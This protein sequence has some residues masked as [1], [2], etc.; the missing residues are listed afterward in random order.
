M[1]TENVA[2]KLA[3][4]RRQSLMV[5]EFFYF[6]LRLRKNEVRRVAQLVAA[7]YPEDEPARN[8]RRLI[9]SK[10]SLS[11]LGGALLN[12]PW[13]LP[14]FGQALKLSGVVG[15]GSLLTR[16]HLYLILEIAHL[17]GEDIDDSARVPEMIAVVAATGLGAA[18]PSLL[19][20]YGMKPALMLPA[21][22]LSMATVTRLVGSSANRFYAARAA[23]RDNPQGAVAD[24]EPSGAAESE[25]P[26]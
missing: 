24:A 11:L 8:A 16:M 21:G 14:G 22:A 23:A 6:F 7:R 12:A 1:T 9:D 17:Y 25:M 5:E 15:A 19:T 2:P 4:E 10:T 20:T 26:A 18:A 13:L 3:A